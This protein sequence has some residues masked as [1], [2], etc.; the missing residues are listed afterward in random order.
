M[1]LLWQLLLVLS[2]LLKK[3]WLLFL[4]PIFQQLLARRRKK[5]RKKLK[6]NHSE[7]SCKLCHSRAGGNPFSK[8]QSKT[9]LLFLF[10]FNYLFGT[11]VLSSISFVVVDGGG[12]GFKPVSLQPHNLDAPSLGIEHLSAIGFGYILRRS[13]AFCMLI[14]SLITK[15]QRKVTYLNGT[16]RVVVTANCH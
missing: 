9:G 8:K 10:N 2:K 1:M 14:G 4:L 12:P 3:K 15:L 16:D 13:V 6:S 5:T 11:N 7:V